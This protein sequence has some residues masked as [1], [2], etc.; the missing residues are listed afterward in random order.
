LDHG[1]SGLG[2]S[3]AVGGWIQVAAAGA[4]APARVVFV[5]TVAATSVSV[6]AWAVT[7]TAL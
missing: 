4:A 2:G 3:G 7:P 6:I 5:G 1:G